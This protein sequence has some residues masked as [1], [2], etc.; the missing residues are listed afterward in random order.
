[1]STK[2]N[3]RSPYFLNLTAPTEA[4]GTFI[5]SE[6]NSTRAANPYGFAVASDG[7]ITLPSLQRGTI[8][9]QSVEKFAALSSG[10]ADVDRT[11]TLTIQI[12][13]GYANTGTISCDVT[14]TQTAPSS[15]GECPSTSGSISDITLTQTTGT[16]SFSVASKFS[17][18]SESISSY[19]LINNH[20][21]YV[22]ASINNSTVTIN[23]LGTC[24]T[25]QL[26]VQANISSKNCP[27]TQSFN[28][29]ING[30][31]TFDCTTANLQGGSISQDGLT[32]TKPNALGTVGDIYAAAT[33]GSPI[34]S[35]SANGNSDPQPVTLYFEITIPSGFD[36]S[37]VLG[38]RC[39]AVL[40]QAGTG[41]STVVCPDNTTETNPA[42]LQYSGW[43]I[44][45]NGTVVVGSVTVDGQA[46]TVTDY[47]TA[48]AANQ[49]T[50]TI[51]RSLSI[52]AT[53]PSS[54][55]SNNSTSITC[56]ITIQ[57][58]FDLSVIG[59][60][61][62]YIS[63]GKST[64]GEFCDSFS[65]ANILVRGFVASVGTSMVG[66]VITEGGSPKSG[67]GNYY[68]I[69]TSPQNPI[70]GAGLTFDLIK[71]NNAGVVEEVIQRTCV[72]AGNEVQL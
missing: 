19:T 3:V 17:A 27:A 52:T 40:T 57:Q 70:A 51:P 21:Q 5:C 31:G 46:C 71:I 38:T 14:A 22:D 34:T 39:S 67:G 68:A 62:F 44:T 10:D 65:A 63:N 48:F 2:I 24:G 54:G 37:G 53:T 9:G 45:Q 16:T 6:A 13:S 50:S 30:C 25:Y 47:T 55:F 69:A 49:G 36:N 56:T 28:V 4:L 41:L 66:T 32:I 58:E 26:H 72:G 43:R 18:G 59:T 1:M 20:T 64:T 11:L 7:T 8:I 42:Y 33:G 61:E 60:N 23:A 35:V 29:I 15:G 12:P